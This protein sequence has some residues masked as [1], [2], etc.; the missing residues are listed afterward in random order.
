MIYFSL[1]MLFR[2][3]GPDLKLHETDLSDVEMKHDFFTAMPRLDS[4]GVF[5]MAT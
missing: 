3:K 4:K 5:V 1:A 2:P